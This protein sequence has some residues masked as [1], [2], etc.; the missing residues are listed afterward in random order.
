[1]FAHNIMGSST[2]LRA[3]RIWLKQIAKQHP[4]FKYNVNAVESVLAQLIHEGKFSGTEIFPGVYSSPLSESLVGDAKLVPLKL[5][6][7]EPQA[8]IP[9]H[10]HGGI[11]CYHLIANSKLLDTRGEYHA[12][13]ACVSQCG[14]CHAVTNIT[15]QAS[16]A[17]IALPVVVKLDFY[18][19]EK[20]LDFFAE[21]YQA[22]N[23]TDIYEFKHKLFICMLYIQA[24]QDNHQDEAA[25]AILH[26]LDKD[27][28]PAQL[29]FLREKSLRLT[30]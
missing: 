22:I 15:D 7:V 1:M 11:E 17:L 21:A 26:S 4:G 23:K 16:Y 10:N 3:A 30:S 18:N 29:Q 12:E 25:L 5:I 2:V 6:K 13:H 19:K 9:L 28:I 24:L 14:E 27:K 8:I 20:T